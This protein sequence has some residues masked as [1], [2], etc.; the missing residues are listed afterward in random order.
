MFSSCPNERLCLRYPISRTAIHLSRPL[1]PIALPL[2]VFNL[3]SGKLAVG[4]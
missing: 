1:T 2:D 3:D 4:L